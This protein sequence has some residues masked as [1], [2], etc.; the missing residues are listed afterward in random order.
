MPH[1]W[2]WYLEDQGLASP[3]T[4]QSF[5]G[6][7][8]CRVACPS[9]QLPATGRHAYTHVRQGWTRH[10]NCRRTL[11]TPHLW[12]SYGKVLEVPEVP[13]KMARSCRMPW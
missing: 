9:R 13:S 5:K 2:L 1:S 11:V 6:R 12:G 10:D 3:R 7:L 8:H 4:C